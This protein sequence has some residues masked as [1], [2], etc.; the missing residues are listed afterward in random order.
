MY[1]SGQIIAKK[2]ASLG[3]K[4]FVR[5]TKEERIA[6]SA[7]WWEQGFKGA[8]FDV[9]TSE[10]PYPAVAMPVSDVSRTQSSLTGTLTNI[11]YFLEI[12]QHTRRPDLP[13]SQSA[14]PSSWGYRQRRMARN[15][16]S[17][18]HKPT[19]RPVT[20]CEPNRP[21]RFQL[22]EPVWIRFGCQERGSEPVVWSF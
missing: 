3:S 11:I 20:W 16:C 12:Q 21:G 15:I 9:P 8:L 6:E 10:L 18:H 1:V 7:G 4:A 5:S 14:H 13:S 22:D 2:Y 19:K 17:S